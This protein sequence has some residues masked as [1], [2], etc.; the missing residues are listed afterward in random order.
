MGIPNSRSC[1]K[2]CCCIRYTKDLKDLLVPPRVQITCTWQ[3]LIVDETKTL[4]WP[5]IGFCDVSLLW[6]AGMDF[7][8]NENILALLLIRLCRSRSVKG[9]YMDIREERDSVLR[10]LSVLWRLKTTRKYLPVR[11]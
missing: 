4:P 7:A 1:L 8:R 2:E 3:C 11:L 9:D 5:V 10:M 6:R